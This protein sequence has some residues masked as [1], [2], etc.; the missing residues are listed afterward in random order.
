MPRE[1]PTSRTGRA[2]AGRLAVEALV[3]EALVVEGLVIAALV[4]AALVVDAPMLNPEPARTMAT[5]AISAL[6]GA[7]C[8]MSNGDEGIALLK[9]KELKGVAG[10]PSQ[11]VACSWKRLQVFTRLQHNC[12]LRETLGQ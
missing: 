4:I 2:G 12:C 3:V 5:S 11:R 9:R 1:S 10:R 7:D 8:P 6:Q